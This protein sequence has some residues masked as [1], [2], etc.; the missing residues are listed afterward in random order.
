MKTYLGSTPINKQYLGTNGIY[1]MASPTSSVDVDYQAVLT[2]ATSQGYT[3]PS[4][5][6]QTIQNQLVVDMKAAG[7]A[8]SDLS[9][10]YVMATDGDSNYAKINWANP[11]TFNATNVGTPYFITNEGF[12][13]NGVNRALDTGFTPST[14]WGTS[15][16]VSMGG[17]ADLDGNPGVIIGSY[18]TERTQLIHLWS[19]GFTYISLGGNY[20]GANISNQTSGLWSLYDNGAT[21]NYMRINNVNSIVAN[22]AGSL[23]WSTVPLGI[24]ARGKG[25]G[26]YDGWGSSK[27]QMAFYGTR[28][29]S[30]NIYSPFNTY[31]T[32]I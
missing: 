18:V 8:W 24:M 20:G 16:D 12:Q 4:T 2:Y 10:F 7:I 22:L 15:T 30:L 26:T 29:V 25:G 32:S 19:D 23:G 6:Q 31:M 5:G 13:G 14:D 9:L 27:Y 1:F 3:L 21:R 11:G 28:N 17:W